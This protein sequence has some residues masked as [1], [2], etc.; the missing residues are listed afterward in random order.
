MMA[1]ALYL[2]CERAAPD[3][4]GSAKDMG[5]VSSYQGSYKHMKII[6]VKL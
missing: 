5:L 6:I 3:T 2:F 1:T 4:S